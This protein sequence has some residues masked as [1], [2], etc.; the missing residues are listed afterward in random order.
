[1]KAVVV[2]EFGGPEVLTIEET[3]D[4]TPGPRQ[5]VVALEA[6]GVNPVDTY[7]RSGAQ[8]YNPPLPMTPGMDGA[9]VV[10]SVG[11]EV[12][13]VS[14]GDRVWV[15]GSATGTYAEKCLCEETQV[16]LLPQALS[17]E[18]GACL[19]VNY[20]TAYRALVHR[21]SARPGETVLVHGATG[22]VG[23]ATVQLA[24]HYGLNIIGTY[25]SRGGEQLLAEQGVAM[26]VSHKAPDRAEEIGALTDGRGVDL[27]VEML[28]NVNL[29]CDM[30]MLA[31][32]GRILVIGSRGSIE[33]TPR[34][35]MRGEADIRGVLLLVATQPQLDESYAAIRAAAETGSVKPVI[36]Q[37]LPLAEAPRAHEL[38][39]EA[40]SGGKIILVP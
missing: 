18:E 28:A 14:A 36:Q 33:I 1:M 26:R 23:I 39:I 20:A 5:V 27:I 29:E 19:Y 2:H 3:A 16:Q 30:E 11:T 37:R 35:L 32:G 7:R 12:R 10:E 24:R 15:A 31:P 25:G 34:L 38:V 4:P 22:G 13:T 6:A 40:A 9:G 21:G 8:G 17:F